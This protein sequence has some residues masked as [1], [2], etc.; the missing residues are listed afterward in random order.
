V[1]NK[2]EE[3]ISDIKV[4]SKLNKKNFKVISDKLLKL[5]TNPYTNKDLIFNNIDKEIFVR[6]K[7]YEDLISAGE[8]KGTKF[9]TAK[10]IKVFLFEEL[11]KV[12]KVCIESLIKASDSDD[13]VVVDKH[14]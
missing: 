6:I 2:T 4:P 3:I 13:L 9:E 14:K 11:G 10:G 8:N 5:A 7:K 12:D 1:V